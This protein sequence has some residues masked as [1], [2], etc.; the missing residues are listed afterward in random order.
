M[1]DHHYVELVVGWLENEWDTTNYPGSFDGSAP[2]IIDADDAESQSFGGRELHYDLAKNNAVEVSS[3]PNRTNEL[4][5][6]E[7]DYRFEDGV[8]IEV[9]GL[10]DSEFGHISGSDEFRTLHQEVRRILHNHIQGPDRGGTQDAHTLAIFDESNL[11]NQ[12]GDLYLY[13]ITATVRGYEEL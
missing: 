13:D 10:H 4:L 8:A 11:T 1:A 12:Y 2:T 5:G 3:T 6:T 9:A 7:P